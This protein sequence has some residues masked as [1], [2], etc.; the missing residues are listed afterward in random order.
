MQHGAESALVETVSVRLG[1]AFGLKDAQLSISV[2]AL[3]LTTLCD[4]HC[5][6]TIRRIVDR[7]IN[8]HVVTAVQRTLILAEKGEIDRLETQRRLEAIRPYHYPKPV[9]VGMI[10]LSCVCFARLME[11]DWISCLLVFVASSV[12]MSVR[13]LLSQWHF[14]PLVNFFT[15]A[16]VATSVAG[17]GVKAG[18]PVHPGTAMAA[19]VLLLVPGFPLINAVS[20]LVKGYINIGVARWTYAMLLILA[21][22]MGILSALSLWKMK[23]WL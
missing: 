2:N 1:A 12:A 16:F 18:G 6:T 23:G 22:S 13:Q 7:G 5:I 20:D 4:G 11:A 19:S 15:T 8:M 9:V 3:S 10:G 21:S 17:L 14:N